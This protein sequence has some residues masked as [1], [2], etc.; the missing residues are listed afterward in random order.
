M[1]QFP[2]HVCPSWC[3][4]HHTVPSQPSEPDYREHLGWAVHH[5]VDGYAVP[6]SVHLEEWT[7]AGDMDEATARAVAKFAPSL[8]VQLPHRLAPVDGMPT[9]VRIS[10][11]TA[12]L[13]RDALSEVLDALADAPQCPCGDLADSTGHCRACQPPAPRRLTLVP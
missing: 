7:V 9:T 10:L 4:Q 3:Q 5:Q 11:P 8:F 6:L 1:T 12:R 2:E 13:L